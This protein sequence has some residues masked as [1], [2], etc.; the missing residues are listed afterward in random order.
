MSVLLRVLTFSGLLLL[1]HWISPCLL[2]LEPLIFLLGVTSTVAYS[3]SVLFALL[4]VALIP[5]PPPAPPLPDAAT[6]PANEARDGNVPKSP[7][8]YGLHHRLLNVRAESTWLNLGF[9]R[10]TDDFEE[11]CRALARM[12]GQA[13]ELGSGDVLLDVGY[14][15]GDQDLLFWREFG[16]AE[17]VGITSEGSP[18]PN[19]AP[20]S[21]PK[22]ILWTSLCLS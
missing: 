12:V 15:C 11:A 22:C 14:G 2:P 10:D 5:P 17:I 1:L 6:S 21:V 20:P 16:P 18:P 3:D 7:V 13:A 4:R 8:V 19:V 9:W